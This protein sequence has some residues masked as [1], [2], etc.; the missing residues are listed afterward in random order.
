MSPDDR[1]RLLALAEDA[2]KHAKTCRAASERVRWLE[3][4]TTYATLAGES[5]PE[6]FTG[7][8]VI[9]RDD[10]FSVV[11]RFGLTLQGGYTDRESAD[12]FLRHCQNL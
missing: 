9:E 2:Q 12:E 1:S 6:D 4:A 3:Q 8:C 5:S 10:R 11:D 7:L